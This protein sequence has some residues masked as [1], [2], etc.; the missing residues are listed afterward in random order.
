MIWFLPAALLLPHFFLASLARLLIFSHHTSKA[1]EIFFPCPLGP[2][3]AFKSQFQCPSSERVSQ[4]K[5][6]LL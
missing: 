6:A 2:Y 5:A 1:L 3:F 4:P